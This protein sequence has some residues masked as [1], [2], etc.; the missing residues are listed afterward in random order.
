MRCEKQMEASY[1]AQNGK[2]RERKWRDFNSKVKAQKLMIPTAS[3]SAPTCSRFHLFSLS[4]QVDKLE[5][6][7]ASFYSSVIKNSVC[8]TK[9][10]AER[11]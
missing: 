3:F 4:V 9:R 7:V 8:S 1:P 11:S 5:L 6:P 10:R 2:G